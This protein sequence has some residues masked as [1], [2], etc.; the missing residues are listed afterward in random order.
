MDS[1]NDS[2]ECHYGADKF[3]EMYGSSDSSDGGLWSSDSDASMQ[4]S[5]SDESMHTP[6]KQCS[7]ARSYTNVD[8]TDLE[9]WLSNV[10]SGRKDVE[11]TFGILKKFLFLKHPVRLYKKDVIEMVF[12]ICSNLLDTQSSTAV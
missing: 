11:C 5:S 1:D 2:W 12:S 10:E 8:R 4:H 7:S 3:Q 6:C 9:L